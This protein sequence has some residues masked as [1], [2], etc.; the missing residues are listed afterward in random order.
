MG[1]WL[2]LFAG[3]LFALLFCRFITGQ[4]GGVTGDVYGATTVLTETVVLFVFSVV[5]TQQA[6][7]AASMQTMCS[8]LEL[9]WKSL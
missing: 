2:A 1:A 3:V 4:L 5:S 9:L 7:I 6:L 8:V